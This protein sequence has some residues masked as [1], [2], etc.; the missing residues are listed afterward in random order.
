MNRKQFITHVKAFID[1]IEAAGYQ[2]IET[3]NVG[4]RFSDEQSHH[5][6]IFAKGVIFE[7]TCFLES[8]TSLQKDPSLVKVLGKIIPIHN[9][10]YSDDF[11]TII[12]S[13]EDYCVVYT[14][15]DKMV[16]TAEEIITLLDAMSEIANRHTATIQ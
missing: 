12:K 7:R 6:T 15:T 10:S 11:K 8:N 3:N 5:F 14:E 4:L 2:F 1:Q 16:S 13:P 9:T